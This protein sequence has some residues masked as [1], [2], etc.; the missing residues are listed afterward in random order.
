[1]NMDREASLSRR[2]FAKAAVA[3]GG[4]AALAACMDRQG[5]QGDEGVDIPG[6]V[7]DPSTLGPTQFVWETATDDYGN[8]VAPRHHV[9]RLLDYA[10]D[11][12]PDDSDRE[13]VENAFRSLERAFEW[14][15]EGLL[16]SIGYSPA[17]FDRFD[18]EVPDSVDLPQPE[19]LSASEDPEL[20]DSDAVLHLATDNEVALLQAEEAL[21][22][23]RETANGVT[24][25]STFEDVLEGPRENS[26]RRTGFVG[27]GLPAKHADDEEVRGVPDDAP[28]DEDAPLFMNFKSGFKK[29]Q[30]ST[31]RVRI[32]DGPF[33]D[34]TTKHVSKLR[35]NLNQ[36]YNQDSREQR[37]AKMFCPVH[38]E[39]DRVEGIGE[40]LGDSSKIDD[41]IEDPV[42]MASEKGVVGHSQKMAAEAREDDEPLILRRDFDTTD[43]DYTGLHFASLQETIGDFVTTREAMNGEQY[44]EETS[45]GRELNNGIRQYLTTVRRGNFLVPP[46]EHRALPPAR[47]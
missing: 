38:A 3:I 5:G 24:M 16:F 11:G 21:F 46:R 10:G 12:T 8:E 9:M 25:E 26:H 43:G 40:N 34:G 31:D 36:W 28:I 33:A 13:T 41:C 42:E 47:P 6:G 14:S 23:N 29:N 7:D 45:V 30:A 35:T 37:V 15:N 4:S 27:A 17:Y 20:D 22:G 32:Q 19:A 39:E 18:S 44:A 2:D 1:M